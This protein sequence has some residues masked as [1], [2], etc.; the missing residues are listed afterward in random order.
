VAGNGG[1]RAS[2]DALRRVRP[3]HA[4]KFVSGGRAACLL[5][6]GTGSNADGKQLLARVAQLLRSSEQV[7]GLGLNEAQAAPIYLPSAEC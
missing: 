6:G 7:P 2:I 3:F 1:L 4:A 5:A